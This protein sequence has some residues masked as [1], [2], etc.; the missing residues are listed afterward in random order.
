M[1]FEPELM[2]S[3]TSERAK[4]LTKSPHHKTVGKHTYC[5]FGVSSREI[6]DIVAQDAYPSV[7]PEAYN[8]FCGPRNSTDIFFTQQA[9][10]TFQT[11]SQAM[12]NIAGDYIKKMDDALIRTS[13]DIIMPAIRE[14]KRKRDIV[15]RES[16][17]TVKK[18]KSQIEKSQ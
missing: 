1:K 16:L 5:D 13:D 17:E 2:Q 18:A 11:V 14:A 9:E 10:K 15:L 12:D 3:R 7:V 6:T 4:Q 8:F